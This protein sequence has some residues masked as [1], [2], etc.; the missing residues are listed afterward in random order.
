MGAVVRAGVDSAHAA[1]V[2]QRHEFTFEQFEEEKKGLYQSSAC[3]VSKKHPRGPRTRPVKLAAVSEKPSSLA[4]AEPDV[5]TWPQQGRNM[6]RLHQSA[7]DD[8]E[9]SQHAQTAEDDGTIDQARCTLASVNQHP[10]HVHGGC[11]VVVHS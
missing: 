9:P 3:S 2:S 6:D 1:L 10:M 4:A 7:S 11:R 5:N 8:S